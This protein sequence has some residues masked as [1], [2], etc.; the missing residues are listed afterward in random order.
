MSHDASSR[1]AVSA[2]GS[3]RASLGGVF[4]SGFALLC[5]AGAAPVLGLLS[6]IGLGF[7]IN[8]AVLVPLLLLALGLTGWGLWQGRRCHGRASALRLG[9]G[10]A[11]LTV[12]GLFFWIPLAFIGFAAVVLASIWNLRLVR[13]CTIPS[14]TSA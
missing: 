8:D 5:C 7:L 9:L 6:A 2:R 14:S 11:A 4:G 13:A 10:G 3:R 12:G 1:I